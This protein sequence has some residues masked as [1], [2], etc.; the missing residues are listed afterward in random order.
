VTALAL[1]ALLACGRAEA[2]EDE[3]GHDEH[4]HGGEHGDEVVLGEEALANARL[5]VQPAELAPL[6]GRV[7]VPA[8]IALDPRREAQVSAVTAGTI[9]RIAVRPG[10]PV[11]VGTTLATVVSPDLGEAIGAYLSAQAKLETA[12]AKRDR[13]AGL[14][15]DGFSSKSQLMDAEAGLT[16]AAAETEAAEERLRVFGL[17]PGSVRPKAGQH[18]PS[19]FSVR[20]PVDGEVL[21]VQTTLGK[22]VTS[23]EP[24]FHVG[25]LDEVWLVMDVG[26]RNLAAV[27]IG[28]QVSFTVEAYG[29]ETFV[30]TVDQ[31]GGILDPETRTAEAR[32]VVANEGHRLK[33]NM[34]AKA[35]LALTSG[36]TSEG[37][38]SEGIVV[39]AEAVQ[40]IE[41]RPSVFVERA[42]GR[43]AVVPVRTEALPDGRLHLVEGVEPGARLVVGGAFTLKSELAKSALGEGHA[44]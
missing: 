5:A 42:P 29:A 31:I 34:S 4:E 21:A 18:F 30:G 15:G 2:P 39:P 10:D 36:P 23:G 6:D 11:E 33:P 43:F 25:N 13:L 22:S 3:H 24:L 16:V 17:S 41:G 7:A 19:R 14:H 12:R 44:H 26:E 35:Q 32:V 27:Q 1:C 8:R 9:E 40:E 37:P 38:T 20:S 28:A